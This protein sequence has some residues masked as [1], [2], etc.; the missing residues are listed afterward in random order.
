[1]NRHGLHVGIGNTVNKGLVVRKI[2]LNESPGVYFG[3]RGGFFFF[4]HKGLQAQTPRL[5]LVSNS[6]RSDALNTVTSFS[7]EGSILLGYC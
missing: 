1:M 5:S 3:M 6:E 4:H 7:H 2:P